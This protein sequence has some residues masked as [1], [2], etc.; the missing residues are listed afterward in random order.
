[1]T[2]Y[3]CAAWAFEHL[4]STYHKFFTPDMSSELLGLMSNVCLAQAQE[5]VV[6]KSLVDN[7]R[8]V[9]TAK[10]LLQIVDFYQLSLK[11]VEL[12]LKDASHYTDKMVK[13]LKVRISNWIK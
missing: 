6:E 8:S 12:M 3:Q 2:H 9:I 5:C 4:R 7:R 13:A 1:V 10:L 11:T